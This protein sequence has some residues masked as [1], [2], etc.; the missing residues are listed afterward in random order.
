MT[1]SAKAAIV[2]HD[3]LAGQHNLFNQSL[4]PSR[5]QKKLAK[6]N[7]F[8]WTVATSQDARFPTTKGGN[9]PTSEG[10]FLAAYSERLLDLASSDSNVHTLLLEVTQLLKSPLAL[11]N[12]QIVWRV[13]SKNS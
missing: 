1:V 7:S 10:G 4:I 13:L 12:P 2:L 9:K 3:W 8:S 11:Y 5:F 6:S